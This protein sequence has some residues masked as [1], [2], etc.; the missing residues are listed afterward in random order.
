M[1]QPWRFLLW[2]A[3]ST[4]LTVMLLAAWWGW[5]RGGILLLQPGVAWC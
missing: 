4:V 1:K 2:L 5:Q 3:L